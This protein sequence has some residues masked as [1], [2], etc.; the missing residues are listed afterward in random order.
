MPKS[1]VD[2][3]TEAGTLMQA[4]QPAEAVKLLAPLHAANPGHD[5]LRQLMSSARLAAAREAYGRGDL[6][7]GAGYLSDALEDDPNNPRLLGHRAI[8][9]LRAGEPAMAEAFFS[10]A[11][12]RARHA[13]GDDGWIWTQAGSLARQAGQIDRARRLVDARCTAAPDDPE[14][15]YARAFIELACGNMAAG[16][17]AYEAR[18]QMPG[19]SSPPKRTHRPSWDGQSFD[20][21]L[22]IWREQGV[23][24]EI[25]FARHLPDVASRCRQVI[26]ECDP[27]LRSLL[28]R[29][30]P[31]HQFRSSAADLTPNK[32]PDEDFDRHIP[33]ASL[34]G[35]LAPDAAYPDAGAY[36]SADPARQRHYRDQLQ[37][38]SPNRRLIGVSW[39]SKNAEHG[40]TRSPGVSQWEPVFKVPGCRF[41][42]LQYGVSGD[43]AAAR[44]I[45]TLPGLDAWQDLEGLAALTSAM[46]GVV[47]IDNS[48][49]HLAGALAVPTVL[50]LPAYQDWRWQMPVSGPESLYQS[51]HVIRQQTPG[52]WNPAMKAAAAALAG[53]D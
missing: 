48:T 51:V 17:S 2:I 36:L 12:T 30:F 18:W 15:V 9:A 13:G 46:D 24:D 41:I 33:L 10:Q 42:S 6:E 28:S 29:S 3:V 49:V 21:R 47:T 19:F 23:G 43:E 32:V 53:M 16:W 27:R 1:A 5:K 8:V 14:A 45:H 20:G 52:E 50:L 35:I 7:A 4:G 11:M 25:M 38:T 44:G 26:V 22:L 34:P 37:S 40:R 31:G 39:W